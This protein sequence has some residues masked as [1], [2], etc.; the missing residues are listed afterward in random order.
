MVLEYIET[1]PKHGYRFV[2][3]VRDLAHPGAGSQHLYSSR[4]K[5]HRQE[6]LS[7]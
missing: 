5:P 4:R 2:A 7:L 3:E 6:N 1:I